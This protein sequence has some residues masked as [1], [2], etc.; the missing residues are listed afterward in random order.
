MS[1]EVIV[2]NCSP[3]LA[4]IINESPLDETALREPTGALDPETSVMV[5][6]KNR[7]IDIAEALKGTE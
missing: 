4:G 1:E 3:T 7:K 2:K 5:A 6:R